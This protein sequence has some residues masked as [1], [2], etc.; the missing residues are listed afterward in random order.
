MH[1][2]EETVTDTTTSGPLAGV[3]ILDLTAVVSGPMAT[4][5]LA[6][7]GAQVIK[8]EPPHGGDHGR[9]IGPGFDGYSA[10]FA[11]C[12][13]NK[14]SLVV[15]LARPEG[16][17]LVRRLACQVDVFV[18]NFRPGVADRLGIGYDRLRAGNADLIH[19]SITGFGPD[20]PYAGQRA[21]DSAI[22]ALSGFADSQAAPGAEPA[23]VSSLVCDKVAALTMA[24]AIS[25][26]LYARAMGKGGQRVQISLLDANIAFNWPDVMWN[27]TFT[28]PGFVAGPTLAET[29]RLWRTADGHIAVVFIAQD[30][31][32]GWCRALDAGPELTAERFASLAAQRARWAELVPF[33]EAQIASFTTTEVLRRFHAQAVPAGAVHRRSA[34]MTDEQVQHNGTIVEIADA[35]MGAI[36]TARPPARFAGFEPP[37]PAR[38]PDLGRH[39][40]AVLAGFDVAPD[41][42]AALI[43]AGVVRDSG[44]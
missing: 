4:M 36:R 12:N 37:L 29:Y 22:Q 40:R 44:P 25:A 1:D 42:I 19:A 13:R 3:R 10:L 34:L 5:M 18:E 43:G 16:A 30:A 26:A 11:S 9:Y 31:F 41:E 21:Y 6:D 24:Q 20:G 38:A 28:S 39:S 27:H 33:W 35:E 8:L 23:L 32:A 15:D 17:A 2:H 7:Q 14:R